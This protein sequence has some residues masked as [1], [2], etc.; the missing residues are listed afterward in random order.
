M[1][2]GSILPIILSTLVVVATVLTAIVWVHD[3]CRVMIQGHVENGH[4]GLNKRLD[5]IEGKVDQV[6][7]RG[8]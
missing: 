8:K 3:E 1:K 7:L 4:T 6:L 5:R 2:N